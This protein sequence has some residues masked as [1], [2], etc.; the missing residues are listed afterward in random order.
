GQPAQLLHYD[1]PDV[2]TFPR[3]QSPPRILRVD[4]APQE[5]MRSD[6]VVARKLEERK[7]ILFGG[8]WTD[9][10]FFSPRQVGGADIHPAVRR[11]HSGH[12]H[13]VAGRASA[14]HWITET[15][16]VEMHHVFDPERAVEENIVAARHGFAKCSLP[17]LFIIAGTREKLPRIAHGKD[18]IRGVV[19]E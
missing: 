19:S 14:F 1:C 2:I 9:R 10:R 8:P 11:I 13:S 15:Y 17:V 18:E 16:C 6:C 7:V 3:Y 12:V 4:D 5:G